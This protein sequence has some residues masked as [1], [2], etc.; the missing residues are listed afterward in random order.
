VGGANLVVLAAPVGAILELLPAV[1]ASCPGDCTVLDL[2][3]TKAAIVAAMDRLPASVQAVGGH[4]MCGREVKGLAA[5]EPGLYEGQTFFLCRSRHTGPEAETLV[6]ALVAAVGGL[7]WWIDPR[8]HDRLVALV[9]HLPYFAAAALMA[10]AAAAASPGEQVWRAA[11]GGFRD[12]SR[13]AGSEP[14]MMGDIAR[15]NR[16]AILAALRGYRSRIEEIT[17]LLVR[18]DDDALFAWLAARK[19]EY[20]LYRGEKRAAGRES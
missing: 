1:A 3:S 20:E 18:E 5:A 11:A 2:G 16:A 14:R 15:T 6:E 19:W 7:P 8:E 12:S 4:P 13:L 9:S 17:D 10:E